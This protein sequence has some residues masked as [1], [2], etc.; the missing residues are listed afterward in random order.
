MTIKTFAGFTLY[1]GHP[2]NTYGTHFEEQCLDAIQ[3]KFPSISIINP[4][5]KQH[6]NAVDAIKSKKG[7]KVMPYFFE[8]AQCASI[9]VFLPFRD[10]KWAQTVFNVAQVCFEVGHPV[11]TINDKLIL[12][13]IRGINKID[14]LSTDNTR[15]RITMPDGT[16]VPY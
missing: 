11:Y 12:K 6:Q 1:F 4:S 3:K 9:G 16:A 7:G 8:L 13:K 5:N 10:G 2:T 14:V 15:N